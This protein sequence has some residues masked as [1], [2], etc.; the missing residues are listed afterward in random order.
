VGAC[1]VWI[2]LP[3][4]ARGA[5]PAPTGPLRRALES[6]PYVYVSPLKRDG[7]ESRCHA[8]VWFAWLDGGV[9]LITSSESWKARA[10][11]R[12]LAR[13]RIWVGDHGR[14]KGLNA[15]SE[16]FRSAP[17]FEARA[18][19]KRDPALLERLLAAYDAKYPEEIGRWRERMRRGFR[20]GSRVLLRY[21][22]GNRL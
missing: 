10:L 18:S 4:R 21:E 5:E 7:G 3:L 19:V 13:A 17:H 14:R 2:G 12:G 16:A 9:V 6:S 11:A 22:P 8:E 15:G 1:L 20:D